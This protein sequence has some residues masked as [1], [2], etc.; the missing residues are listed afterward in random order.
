M[1][2]GVFALI[3]FVPMAGIAVTPLWMALL[4]VL[5]F[6]RIAIR[7]ALSYIAGSFAFW[8]PAGC[9]ELSDVL[10]GL[11]DTVSDYPL[12]GMPRMVVGVLVTVIPLGVLTYLPGLILLGRLDALWTAWPV[13]LAVLLASA[14]AAFFRKGLKHYV[15][16]GCARYK[17]MGHR[18]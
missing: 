18:S 6:S 12:S 9:E 11:C 16:A 4:F 5:A 17:A 8:E 7:L 14:A 13:F 1:L 2:C 10:L 15:K 3:A